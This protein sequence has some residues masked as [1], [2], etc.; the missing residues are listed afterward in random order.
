MAAVVVSTFHTASHEAMSREWLLPSLDGRF[1]ILQGTGSQSCPAARYKT[2][3]WFDTTLEKVRHINSS[4]ERCIDLDVQAMLFLDADVQTFDLSPSDILRDLG[5]SDLVFQRDT[6]RDDLCTG[7]F[8]ARCGMS[9]LRFWR[10]V[11]KVMTRHP[12]DDQDAVKSLLLGRKPRL[13]DWRL[14]PARYFGGG[15]TSGRVWSPGDPLEVPLDIVV[16]HA[17]WTRG[18]AD[19]LAQLRYVR[20][21][22]NA[23]SDQAGGLPSR[24]R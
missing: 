16:H 1:E 17:N 4:L 10:L 2:D 14:L 7:V 5:G 6:P 22:V 15:A 8:I 3:G 11:E 24:K 21:V 9:V 13:V 18:V 12:C 23:R 19:K 20:D